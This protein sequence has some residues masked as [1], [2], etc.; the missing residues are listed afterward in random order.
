[1]FVNGHG[2][3]VEVLRAAVELLRAEGR[4]A[5]W[6][7]CAPQAGFPRDAHAGR[8]ETSIMLA[9]APELVRPERAE[10]GNTEPLSSLLPAL[11]SGGVRAASANGVLGD[12][13]G[14]SAV[15]GAAML[16]AMVAACAELARRPC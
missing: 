12:P 13:A 14:A 10:P 11:R 9:V 7:G 6:Y 4:D 15:E 5:R 8:A 1:V 2:G 3:N 16:A